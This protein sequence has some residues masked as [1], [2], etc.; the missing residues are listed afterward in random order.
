MTAHAQVVC[1]T[2]P[3]IETKKTQTRQD[4]PKKQK[5]HADT[6]TRGR[7]PANYYFTTVQYAAEYMQYRVK[8]Q[9]NTDCADVCPRLEKNRKQKQ[10]QKQK[11]RRERGR[12]RERETQKS[13][14]EPE[15]ATHTY[16][17]YVSSYYQIEAH[18]RVVQSQ[19]GPYMSGR[20]SPSKNISFFNDNE[21]LRLI[22]CTAFSANLFVCNT[23]AR[24]RAHTHTHT[25]RITC[26]PK[27]INN[28]RSVDVKIL[29]VCSEGK[30]I[31]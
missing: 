22:F 20:I 12:E 31:P 17:I 23:L 18:T 3:V 25:S 27:S 6:C 24:A 1:D 29:L 21:R 30:W 8:T 7:E 13:R 14:A 15:G 19:K 2:D 10:K 5:K 26:I 11:K 16:T 9:T 28:I 4:P